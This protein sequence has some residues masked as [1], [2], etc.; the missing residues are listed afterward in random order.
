MILILRPILVAQSAEY[1]DSVFD[2]RQRGNAEQYIKHR[3]RAKPWHGSASNVLN[4]SWGS[5]ESDDEF[6]LGVRELSGPTI[7]VIT[8]MNAGQCG[9]RAAQRLR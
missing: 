3:L 6:A 7:L 8:E 1:L 2:I 5:R 9:A 4:N